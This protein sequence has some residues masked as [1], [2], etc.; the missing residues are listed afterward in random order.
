[1]PSKKILVID[2]EVD[3]LSFIKETLE[4]RGFN[5]VT[6]SNAIAAGIEL[7]SKP[8]ALILMDLKMP[9]ID[10]LQ[11]CQAIRSNPVTK[12]IPIIAVSALADES[13]KRKARKLKVVEYF[14][15]PVN[16]ENL[17]KKINEVLN[18]GQPDIR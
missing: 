18:V 5:I 14:V 4:L 12:D 3:F 13:Y 9:G 17:I 16:V 15:K 7:A 8:P 6:A 10:G 1:M 11:A 2:D